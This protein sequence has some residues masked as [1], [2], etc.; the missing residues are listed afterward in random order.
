[1]GKPACLGQGERGGEGLGLGMKPPL[2]I[3]TARVSWPRDTTP[4]PAAPKRLHTRLSEPGCR[5]HTICPAA[6][7]A[8]KT[9]PVENPVGLRCWCGQG[10][11]RL[12]GSARPRPPPAPRGPPGVGRTVQPRSQGCLLEQDT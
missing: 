9:R 3:L 7:D 2:P 4:F 8:E 1:M 10:L 6:A 12:R 5:Q 11:G